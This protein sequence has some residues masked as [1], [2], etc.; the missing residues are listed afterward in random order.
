MKTFVRLAVYLAATTVLLVLLAVAYVLSMDISTNV[1]KL[2]LAIGVI[3]GMLQ[4]VILG[5]IIW[6]GHSRSK[7]PL[8]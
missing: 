5:E 4:L 2:I 6:A 3:I 8:Q 1:N 7:E